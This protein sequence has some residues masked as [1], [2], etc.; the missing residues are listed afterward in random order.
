MDK[1]ALIT[2]NY[3]STPLIRRLES[4]I[5]GQLGLKLYVVDNS[6]DF[7]TPY[8]TTT[9]INSGGNVGFACACNLAARQSSEDKLFFINPDLEI[10]LKSLHALI[11]EAPAG[12]KAIWGPL[13]DNGNG[14]SGAI[15]QRN[16]RFV[17]LQRLSF[18][19]DRASAFP[20]LYISGACLCVRRS[21]F[22]SLGGFCEQI[23]MYGEDLDLCLRT[24]Q[25]GGQIMTLYNVVVRHLSGTGVKKEWPYFLRLIRWPL[26]QRISTGIRGHYY[27]LRHHYAFLQSC[28]LAVYLVI[29][30]NE[31][32]T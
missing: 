22:L 27:A 29:G 19:L 6:G 30:G 14:R 25:Q 23:F 11:S 20:S 28:F 9:V 15:V 32:V 16:N 12:E 4:I 21:H 17:P 8:E 5:D 1:V 10:D 3:Y 18:A 24:A 13:I 2:I 31:S 7:V 26:I